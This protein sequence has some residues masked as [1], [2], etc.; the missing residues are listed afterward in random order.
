MP[1]ASIDQAQIQQFNT[2]ANRLNILPIKVTPHYQRLVDAE[3]ATLGQPG[4]PLYRV[5]YPD[6]ERLLLRAPHEVPD[7]VEDR[8]NMP[9]DLH[10][11]LIHKY[12]QRALFL[13]TDRCAAH[14]MY[15]FRQD[16]LSAMHAQTLPA[17]QQKLDAV[18]DYLQ[19]HPQIREVILSG[20]DPLNVSLRYLEQILSRLTQETAVRDIR[21]H[22][23][24]V[25]FAPRVLSEEVCRLLGAYQA[26]LYLHVVHPYELTPEVTE[27][28]ARLQQYGVRTYS[29][30]PILRGINDHVAVLEELL[31]ALDA[32]RANPINV[33]IPDPISYSASFR[34]P[35]TRLLR[36][37]D[38]LYWETSS[39]TNGVRLVL[40]TPVGKVRR[41]DIVA[42]D[43]ATGVVTFAREGNLVTYHDFPE[44][45][46]VPGD[47][48]LLLWKRQDVR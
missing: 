15:C 46:D 47:P 16:V 39:W 4:G 48:D 35:L 31:R 8:T 26:R 40:D 3:L 45:L 34:M 23:R 6:P 21:V 14:C 29:Q 41:E 9:A 1:H 32:L 44:E 24:N 27:G 12:R 30:F 36:L 20:G 19:E 7:F 2:E 11:V 38:Q 22:T 42:W 5:V 33:F 37:M 43:R 25:V 17:M 18:I 10:N 28:V 13:V